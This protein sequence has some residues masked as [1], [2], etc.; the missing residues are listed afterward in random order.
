MRP[1]SDPPPASPPEI[2]PRGGAANLVGFAPPR[3]KAWLNAVP[4]TLARKLLGVSFSTL[5]AYEAR[6]LLRPAN[7]K[8]AQ[9]TRRVVYRRAEVEA[10][11]LR[12]RDEREALAPGVIAARAFALFEERKTL[13]E[14]VRELRV[15]PERVRALYREWMTP[16]GQTPAPAKSRTRIK[17]TP[18]TLDEDVGPVAL[19][20]VYEDDP[21][22]AKKARARG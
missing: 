9:G 11:M 12:L 16:L 18:P 3:G 8:N 17:V 7:A 5:R 2:R 22:P 6:G 1:T 19:P 10:L 13:A 21:P 15:E 4:R 20:R 14:V